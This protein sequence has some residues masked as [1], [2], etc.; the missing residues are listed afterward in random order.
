MEGNVD[1][2]LAASTLLGEFRNTYRYRTQGADPS[3]LYE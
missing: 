1:I 2:W 3:P